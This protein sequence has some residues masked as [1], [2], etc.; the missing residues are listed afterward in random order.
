MFYLLSNPEVAYLDCVGIYKAFK[1]A[2]SP[3]I[4]QLDGEKNVDQPACQHSL[5][6]PLIF[7]YTE[8]MFSVDRDHLRC[9]HVKALL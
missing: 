8:S 4:E 7:T 5:S 3:K 9:Q 6:V 2:A 1:F